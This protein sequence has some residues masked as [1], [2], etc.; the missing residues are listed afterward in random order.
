M[1]VGQKFIVEEYNSYT[2]TSHNA[3]VEKIWEITEINGNDVTATLLSTNKSM[4]SGGF[5]K[6]FKDFKEFKNHIGSQKLFSNSK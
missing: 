6:V 5:S 2:I 4:Y 3:T 1:K